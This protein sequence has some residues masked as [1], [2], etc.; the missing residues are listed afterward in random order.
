[1]SGVTISRAALVAMRDVSRSTLPE[2][3]C[4]LLRGQGGHVEEVTVAR[5]VAL[6]RVHRFEIDP[7]DLFAALRDE[8]AGGAEIV[9]Y[10]HSHPNGTAIPSATDAEVAPPDGKLWVIVADNEITAWR[11][12]ADGQVHGR[13]VAVALSP[14]DPVPT[15]L[16]P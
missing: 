4:G 10:W 2:E 5:N 12:V 13:F 11:A 1:M 8:R 6:D 16:A 14:A 7:I 15:A 3:A 9:G